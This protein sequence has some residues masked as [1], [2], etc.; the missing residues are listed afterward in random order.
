MVQTRP[1][2]HYEQVLIPEA[3]GIN[4]DCTVLTQ[5]LYSNVHS[6]SVRA[7]FAGQRYMVASKSR[8][9]FGQDLALHVLVPSSRIRKGYRARNQTT[10]AE[11]SSASEASQAVLQWILG[12]K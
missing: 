7:S 12:A 6:P 3:Y 1:T 9:D 10:A 8:S 11:D 5:S 2:Y 4:I